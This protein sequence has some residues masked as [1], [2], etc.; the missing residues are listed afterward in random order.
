MLLFQICENWENFC[1]NPYAFNKRG[2]PGMP[3]AIDGC[4]F[5]ILAAQRE[6]LNLNHVD[7]IKIFN[8]LISNIF[9]AR[10]AELSWREIKL[11][12]RNTKKMLW[13]LS[14]VKK[15]RLW[16]PTNSILKFFK[17][18]TRLTLEINVFCKF[19]CKILKKNILKR[20]WNI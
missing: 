6:I 16:V 18:I 11:E 10:A 3:M 15:L 17:E 8:K 4:G 12:I 13:N 14:T 1:S 20:I 19:W 9:Q 2:M 7:A 5:T